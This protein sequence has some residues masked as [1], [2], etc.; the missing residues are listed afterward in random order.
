MHHIRYNID[1]CLFSI[2]ICFVSWSKLHDDD[3]FFAKDHNRTE[4]QLNLCAPQANTMKCSINTFTFIGWYLKKRCKFIAMKMEYALKERKYKLE[5]TKFRDFEQNGLFDCKREAFKTV[6]TNRASKSCWNNKEKK[7]VCPTNKQT[8]QQNK[9]QIRRRQ[10]YIYRGCLYI[11]LAVLSFV[12]F[13]I[14]L[15]L[16]LDNLTVFFSSFHSIPFFLFFLFQTDH[17]V[18][19]W[20]WGNG[21]LRIKSSHIESNAFLV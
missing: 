4:N 14:F 21:T 18:W 11:P 7:M 10:R 13:P 15:Q 5:S 12:T 9:T 19:I 16:N 1:M 2:W 17:R 3:Q 6:M 20:F 8:N